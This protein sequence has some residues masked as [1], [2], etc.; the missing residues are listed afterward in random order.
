MALF[1]KLFI[2]HQYRETDLN[3]FF[4]HE[5]QAF[6]PSLSEFGEL[7]NPD[8]KSQLLDCIMKSVTTADVPIIIAKS[9][10]SFDCKILDGPAVVHFLNPAGAITFENYADGVFIP[11]ENQLQTCSHLDIVWDRYLNHSLKNSIGENRGQGVR[12]KVEGHLKLPGN[13]AEFLRESCNKRELF[14]FLSH[15]VVSYQFRNNKSVYITGTSVLTT[16]S[17]PMQRCTREEADSRIMVHLI[18]A[19]EERKQLFQVRTVD[20][21]VVIILIGNFHELNLKYQLQDV[22]II[23]GTCRNIKI[24]SIKTICTQLGED[25]S[26]ALPFF[27][28]FTGCDTTSFFRDKGKRTAWQTWQASRGITEVFRELSQNYF[29]EITQNSVL[30][31]ALHRL[32][33]TLYSRTSKLKNVNEARKVMFSGNQD[34]EKLPPT[35]DALLQHT[36]RSLFQTGVWTMTTAEPN[37]PLPE[38]NGWKKRSL[39]EVAKCSS[40][41]TKCKCSGDCPSCSCGKANLDCTPLCKCKCIK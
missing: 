28:S 30:F 14:Q 23:F 4:C 5:T 22:S 21:D 25:T 13:W 3:E 7:Y 29:M 37:Y 34:M 39:P 31:V 27:H 11:F 9:T 17:N 35:E 20:T 19:L 36:K 15:R 12:W 24:F 6:P 38:D 1:G 33:V 40:Q 8:T 32:V 10:D 26:K 41:L 16:A 2:A 18:H